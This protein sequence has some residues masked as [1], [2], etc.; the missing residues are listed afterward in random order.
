MIFLKGRGMYGRINRINGFNYNKMF[1]VNVCIILVYI[2]KY[3]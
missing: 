3:S 2:N 1:N